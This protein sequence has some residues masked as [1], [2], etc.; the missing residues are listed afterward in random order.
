MEENQ[1]ATLEGHHHMLCGHQE[2]YEHDV[3]RSQK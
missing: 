1:G 3:S 2:A